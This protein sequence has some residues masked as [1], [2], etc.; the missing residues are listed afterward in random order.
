MGTVF[1]KK[2]RKSVLQNIYPHA[3]LQG[4]KHLLGS[5]IS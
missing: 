3:N 1:D 4:V 2:E 5:S